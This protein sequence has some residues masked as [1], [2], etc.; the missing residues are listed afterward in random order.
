MRETLQP[1]PVGGRPE[2]VAARQAPAA[3]TREGV[4]TNPTDCPA[5]CFRSR[6]GTATP[7]LDGEQVGQGRVDRNMPMVFSDDETCD[8]GE[9]GTPVSDDYDHTSR[10]F[11]GRVRWVQIDLG[12]DVDDA[13]HRIS[14]EERVPDR[15]G[16]Q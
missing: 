7:F 9:S 6:S 3:T 11:T 4:P 1:Q 5:T 14:E 10:A 15:D 13:G 2:I 12:E 8:V 16:P